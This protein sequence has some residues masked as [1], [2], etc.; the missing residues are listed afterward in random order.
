M[1]QCANGRLFTACVFRVEK[2]AQ[3]AEFWH[4]VLDF[5]PAR[6]YDKPVGRRNAMLLR[7]LSYV[8]TAVVS[9]SAGAFIMAV[10]AGGTRKKQ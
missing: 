9:A 1:P 2:E 6:R 5:Y 7:V 8:V 3:K 10:I 4:F